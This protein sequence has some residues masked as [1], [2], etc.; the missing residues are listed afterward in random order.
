[1]RFNIVDIIIVILLVSGFITGYKKGL[2]KQ[3]ISTIGLIACV[4]LAFLLKNNLSI[5][6]YEKCPFFTVGLLRNYSSLNILFYELISFFILF[7][8][9]SIILNIIL[10]ITGIVERIADDDGVFRLLFKIL[11]GFLGILESY[12]SI[13]IILLILCMPIFSMKFTNYIHKS[14]LKNHILNNTI[15]ISNVAEPVV[16]T[17]NS[18]SKLEVK[19]NIGKEEFNCKTIEIFKKNKIISEE[20]LKYLK[21]TKK[22][23]IK[24][25]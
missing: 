6:L 25:D 11:G 19:K 22:L 4:I 2:I 7:V 23:D 20:S 17:I 13:F 9:F 21:D 12:V 3:A 10:K 24:C 15:L 8:I 14:K 1:M 5:V 18:I 16:K